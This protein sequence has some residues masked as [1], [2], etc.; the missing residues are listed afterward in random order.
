MGQ[1]E[2]GGETPRVC[3]REGKCQQAWL[4]LAWC[5]LGHCIGMILPSA[6]A[7]LSAVCATSIFENQ[8]DRIPIRGP[9]VKIYR[10]RNIHLLKKGQILD[11]LSLSFSLSLPENGLGSEVVPSVLLTTPQFIWV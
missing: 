4:R 10:G 5:V 3:A 8:N 9:T 2:D 11:Q 1:P 7:C 6:S